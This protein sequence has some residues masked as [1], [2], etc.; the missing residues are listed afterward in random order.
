MQIVYAFI[1]YFAILMLLMT[2][3]LLVF[4]LAPARRLLHRFRTTFA[5]IF[6]NE[7][8]KYTVYFCFAIILLILFESIY[9]F[10]TLNTHFKRST[11]SSMQN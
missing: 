11:P 9:T 2:A 6:Q 3:S 7:I 5:H 8:V 4:L 10:S 1:Y